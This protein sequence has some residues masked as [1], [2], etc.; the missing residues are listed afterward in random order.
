[1]TALR[2]GSVSIDVDDLWDAVDT[3]ALVAEVADRLDEPEVE[4]FI[5]EHAPECDCDDDRDDRDAEPFI[6]RMSDWDREALVKAIHEDDGR[7]AI[8]LLREALS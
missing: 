5:N 8:D 6:E 2:V 4:A 1:M 7:R 3:K